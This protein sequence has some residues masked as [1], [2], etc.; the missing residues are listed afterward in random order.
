MTSLIVSLFAIATAVGIHEFAHSFV[1]FKLGD[2]TAKNSG[3]M[4]PN[5]FVHLDPIG[6]LM[7]IFMGVGF[8]MPVP[9]NS[10]NF[11]QK[12]KKRDLVLVSLAGAGFNVLTAI[13]CAVIMKFIPLASAKMVL[14]TV[15]EYNLSFAAFNLI[16]IIPPLDGWQILKQFIPYKYYESVYQYESMSIFIF[17]VMILTDIH[18]V[19]MGPIYNVLLSIVN[20]FM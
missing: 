10:N 11:K 13:L 6:L 16:P 17:I 19:I 14:V 7:M 15:I 9:I 4:T 8:A 20:M 3:R 12:T 5:P 2:P 1:A 18:M